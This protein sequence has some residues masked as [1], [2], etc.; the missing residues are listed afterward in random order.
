M[1]KEIENKYWEKEKGE[2]IEFGKK[3]MR[4]YDKAGKLQFGK[5]ISHKDSDKKDYVILFTLDREELC[6]SSEGAPYLQQTIIEWREMY[7]AE[8]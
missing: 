4:C 1:K 7:N 3:F 2:L 8:D 6:S 5:V